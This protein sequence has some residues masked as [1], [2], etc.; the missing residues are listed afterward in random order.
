[1][2]PVCKFI[3]MRRAAFSLVE[4][5]VVIC[6]ISVLA[7][8]SLPA[9]NRMRHY[10]D[11]QTTSSN[12]RTLGQAIVLYMGENDGSLPGPLWSGNFA[13]Y[14]TKD[15]RT[16]GYRLWSYLGLPAPTNVDREA[17]ILTNPA[18]LRQRLS[19]TAPVYFCYDKIS[20]VGMPTIASPW[21]R[22]DTTANINLQPIRYAQISSYGPADAPAV[23]ELDQKN[24]N[25]AVAPPN[26]PLG[27]IRMTLYFD[28][29][30]A[31]VPVTK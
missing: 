19:T 31:P 18:Y 26:P 21:G 3:T 13:Y 29:H 6:I 11:M 27:D 23:T 10:M 2:N 8:L 25:S 28:W 16:L 15:D 1:M 4:L 20:A 9:L 24:Y 14:S 22:K 12:L 17:K 5:L 7:A 30:V